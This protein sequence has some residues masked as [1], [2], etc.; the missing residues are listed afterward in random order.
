MENKNESEAQ[1]V[2]T[3]KRAYQ[4]PRVQV[5][6]NLSDITETRTNPAAHAHD[7]GASN[8]PSFPSNRT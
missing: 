1:S 4:K 3:G 7:P 8:P 2:K 5:Y 6:G